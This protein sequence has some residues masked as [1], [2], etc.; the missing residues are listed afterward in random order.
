LVG[1]VSLETFFGLEFFEFGEEVS[2]FLV[3]FSLLVDFPR[4]MGFSFSVIFFFG[5]TVN[6]L[7]F[8]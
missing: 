5:E 2:G 1:F 8:L 4:G 3:L 7:I 6:G